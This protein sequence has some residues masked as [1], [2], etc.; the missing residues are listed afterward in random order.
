MEE[1]NYEGEDEE[2]LNGE[3]DVEED[4]MDLD[5]D[6]VETDS[7][8]TSEDMDDVGPD[9]DNI[10]RDG[11]DPEGWHESDED[12]DEA[13]DDPVDMLEADDIP[14]EEID[15]ERDEVWQVCSPFAFLCINL[16]S[17]NQDMQIQ[18]ELEND[19]DDDTG[20]DVDGVGGELGFSGEWFMALLKNN[21][22]C[23]GRRQR[24]RGRR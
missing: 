12:G 10:Q 23:G 5:Y 14:D 15:P 6:E 11:M 2:M 20:E 17:L 19:D 21:S 1:V 18:E 8:N 13:P 24:G 4:D 16:I 9:D 7:E 3:E 22:S